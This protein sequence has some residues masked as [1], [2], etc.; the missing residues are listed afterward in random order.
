MVVKYV[1]DT[2]VIE[3]PAIPDRGKLET[4]NLIR[5]QKQILKLSLLYAVSAARSTPN[6]L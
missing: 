1:D 3:V 2:A 4:N 6:L 5:S